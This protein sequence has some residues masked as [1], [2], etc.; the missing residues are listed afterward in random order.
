M[1][2]IIYSN[3]NSTNPNIR[4]K[5][6]YTNVQRV[7][8]TRTVQTTPDS[9]K[10]FIQSKP[11]HWNPIQEDNDS[12]SDD[13]DYSVPPITL[14][15]SDNSSRR[16]NIFYQQPV[17]SISD[18]DSSILS[19]VHTPS[20]AN[21]SRPQSYEALDDWLIHQRA[22]AHEHHLSVELQVPQE[23]PREALSGREQQK[24]LARQKLPSITATFLKWME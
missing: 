8:I 1:Q 3:S 24:Q 15:T 10:T 17:L 13:E 12:S 22:Q 19:V 16:E 21:N 9:T 18:E 4:Q 5:Q 11:M 7:H 2:K 6:Y 23:Q 20:T 14:S